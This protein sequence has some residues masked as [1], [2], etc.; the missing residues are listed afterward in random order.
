MIVTIPST[1]PTLNNL[2]ALIKEVSL[3]HFM[4]K[5]FGFGPL[6]NRNVEELNTPYIWCEEG[7]SKMT[8]GNMSMKTSEYTFT[9]YCM[10]RIQKDETNYQEILSDTKFI[11]DTIMTELDQHPLFIQ[12]GLTYNKNQDIIYNPI[13]EETDYNANGHSAEFTWKFAFRL[14]PC[15]VP[16][17]YNLGRVYVLDGYW[18]DDY[19]DKE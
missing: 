15:T 8:Q 1:T 5:D 4:I 16:I 6:W 17:Q 19:T 18:D 11:L 2:V 10:D 3:N 13:Y 9:L 12:L 7:Q 14:T